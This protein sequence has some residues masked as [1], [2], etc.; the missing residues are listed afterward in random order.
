MT[1]TISVAD[2]ELNCGRGVEETERSHHTPAL[3]TT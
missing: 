2:V 1:I 3:G